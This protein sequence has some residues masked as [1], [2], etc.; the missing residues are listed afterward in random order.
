[1]SLKKNKTI[2]IWFNTISG[3]VT[4]EAD[5]YEANSCSLDVNNILREITTKVKTRKMKRPTKDQNVS[6]VQRN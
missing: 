6:R 5:G 3:E 1:M 2:E 4:A